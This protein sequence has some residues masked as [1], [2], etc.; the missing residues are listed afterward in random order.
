M[1][2]PGVGFACAC[3]PA[4]GSAEQVLR[5]GHQKEARIIMMHRPFSV[6]VLLVVPLL[7]LGLA[8][9]GQT[10]TVLYDNFSQLIDPAKWSGTELSLGPGAPNTEVVR[11]TVFG[12]LLIY[13]TTAGLTTSNSGIAGLANA[14]IGATNPTP[15][16]LWQADAMV[17]VATAVSC[18]ANPAPT[19]SGAAV[20]G[21]FFNDGTSPNPGG[22]DRTG[23][24][25]GGIQKVLDSA[26]TKQFEAFYYRCSNAGCTTVDSIVTH[27]FSGVQWKPIVFDTL[28]VQWNQAQHEFVFA[29]N[30]QGGARTGTT[31]LTYSFS[32][33]NP[34]VAPSRVLG[35]INSPANCMPPSART[36]ATGWVYFDNA[37][38]NP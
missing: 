28:R 16:T 2:E 13:L 30:P 18:A 22:G 38:V 36:Q 15:I 37:M 12:E 26:G 27:V 14:G 5:T 10:Q 29:L 3:D 35:V 8:G 24:V 34:A 7:L 32:D 9:P 25:V 4:S 23:D 1:G 20:F 19:R 31:V 21:A 11:F 6:V 17:T 33:I